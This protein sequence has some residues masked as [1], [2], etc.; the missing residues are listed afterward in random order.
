MKLSKAL[1]ILVNQVLVG[2]LM[3]RVYDVGCQYDFDDFPKEAKQL[4]KMVKRTASRD[5]LSQMP[6][7]NHGMKAAISL[8]NHW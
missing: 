5:S 4:K 8:W 2:T 3:V 1:V 7:H 6:D